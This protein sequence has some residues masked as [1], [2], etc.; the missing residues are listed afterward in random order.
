MN[1]NRWYENGLRAATAGV[2]ALIAAIALFVG[3]VTTVR[4]A[5]LYDNCFGCDG[6]TLHAWDIIAGENPGGVVANSFV[7]SVG[8]TVDDFEVALWVLHVEGVT[9][10][11]TSVD[12]HIL[13]DDGGGNP[14]GGTIIASGTAANPVGTPI[15]TFTSSGAEIDVLDEEFNIPGVPLAGGTTYWLV[16]FNGLATSN[17]YWDQSD[18]QSTAFAS[19][20]VEEF[21]AGTQPCNDNSAIGGGN[22]TD[23][24]SFKLSGTTGSVT[25]PEPGTLLLLGL[26]AAM[27][28]L[29]RAR[30]LG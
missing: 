5:I 13:A 8:A 12:W 10:S 20:P 3:A 14:F 26:G 22:C 19:T 15:T 24:E 28:G 4:A 11:V 7:L 6:Y 1:I 17:V 21:I 16:L 23:S 18:G 25:V 30:R 27:M 29:A 9:S 2:V